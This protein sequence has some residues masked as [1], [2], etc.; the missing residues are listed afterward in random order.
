MKNQKDVRTIAFIAMLGALSAVLMAIRVPLPFALAFLEFDIAELPALFAGF[1]LGPVSG[2]GVI[3]VKNL[4]KLLTQGTQT[5]FVGDFM[6]II[7]S[8]CFML[9]AALI[10]R[11]HHTKK[12]AVIGLTAATLFVSVVCVF[13]NAWISFPMY[14]RI[15]GM[16]MESIVAMGSAVNPLVTDTVTLML[17]SIFPFNLVKHG[18][19]ALVTYLV[20]KRCG[21]DLRRVLSPGKQETDRKKSGN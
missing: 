4:L 3:V 18:V 14:S 5:A 20:Y 15:Y 2:C 1:F 6:N 21:N 7:S 19:T 13:L 8:I 10:Y 12:G 11:F 17:F 9:P 16:S